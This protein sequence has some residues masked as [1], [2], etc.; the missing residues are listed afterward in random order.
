MTSIPER[1]GMLDVTKQQLL[2]KKA[3]L[4]ASLEYIAKKEKYYTDVLAGKVKYT[5]NLI[6]VD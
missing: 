6:D 4:D 1:R 3:E 5:S 2:A